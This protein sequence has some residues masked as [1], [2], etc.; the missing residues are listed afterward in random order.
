MG[1][2]S[3]L[4]QDGLFPPP[5]FFF[6]LKMWILI[7]HGCYS[8]GLCACYSEAALCVLPLV[9]CPS[10]TVLT[11]CR[12]YVALSTLQYFEA[13][14]CRR[15]AQETTLAK[16]SWPDSLG[17]TVN[18]GAHNGLVWQLF[19]L[20]GYFQANSC[21]VLLSVS[22]H[23]GR[24][25]QLTHSHINVRVCVCV[26][27]EAGPACWIALASAC[28]ME[29]CAFIFSITRTGMLYSYLQMTY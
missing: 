5:P 6:W 9:I 17:F 29:I 2:R 18:P 20:A 25:P 8:E 12:V 28:S 3:G 11:S 22:Y 16:C 27:C 1:G 23:G 15:Q 21:T 26:W 10:T 4:F 14:Q 7:R 13:K 19:V 24:S